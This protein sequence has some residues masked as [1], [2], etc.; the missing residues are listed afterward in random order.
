MSTCIT[1]C[2]NKR[3]L[4]SYLARALAYLGVMLDVLVRLVLIAL[5]IDDNMAPRILTL[6]NK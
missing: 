1:C 2:V 3:N 5:R 4:I 6:L